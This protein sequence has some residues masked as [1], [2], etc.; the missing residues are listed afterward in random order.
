MT[1][2]EL[3]AF[4]P[5]VREAYAEDMVQNA[6]AEYEKARAKAVADVERLFPGGAR[7]RTYLPKK[8]IR[9]DRFQPHRAHALRV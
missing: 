8:L 3:A 4:L 5:R 1:D 7:S 2:E 9:S 6:G